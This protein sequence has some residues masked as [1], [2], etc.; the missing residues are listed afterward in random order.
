MI[1]LVLATGMQI[2][3]CMKVEKVS[4]ELY[5]PKEK[6]FQ[7]SLIIEIW[8]THIP[9]VFLN[10]IYPVSKCDKISQFFWKVLPPLGKQFL[11][12]IG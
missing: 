5:L 1:N 8:K 6:Q 4:H 12:Y 9:S 10:E 11:R 2:H 3:G 7:R